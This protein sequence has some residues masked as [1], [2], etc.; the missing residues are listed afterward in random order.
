MVVNS[1][2]QHLLGAVLADNVR[3]QVLVDL[4]RRRQLGKRQARFGGG[5]RGRF[6]VDN[7]AAQIDALVADVDGAGSSD[8]PS[9][10]V[11]AFSAKRAVILTASTACCRRHVGVVSLPASAAVLVVVWIQLR[12]L[13]A[14]ASH[15]RWLRQLRQR[16]R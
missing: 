14:N 4:G 1:N 11:L 7:F 8:E 6:F 3:V 2:R 16:S 12:G 10:L 13:Q 15:P 5:W 9:D